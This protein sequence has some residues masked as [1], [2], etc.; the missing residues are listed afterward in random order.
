MSTT[1]RIIHKLGD[2]ITVTARMS[3]KD[4]EELKGVNVAYEVIREGRTVQ[5]SGCIGRIDSQFLWISGWCY[6]V[7]GEVRNLR[8]S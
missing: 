6:F 4:R 5:R 2:P 7:E 3:D 8:R 1:T